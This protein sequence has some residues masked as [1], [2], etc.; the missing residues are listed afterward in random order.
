MDG[1]IYVLI[2]VTFFVSI[3]YAIKAIVDARVRAKLV[4]SNTSE[5]LIRAVLLGEEMQ[6]RYASLRWGIVL[7]CLAGG[8]GAIGVMGWDRLTPGV[9][10]V[11]LAATGAGNL[12]SYRLGR[13]RPQD[14]SMPG[15]APRATL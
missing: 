9:I 15:R 13:D 12:I 6:R 7:L 2:P 1:D 14:A 4:A 10:A 8:F 5:E 11:L 3:A